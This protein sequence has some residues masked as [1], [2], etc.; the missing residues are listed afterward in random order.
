M[1]Q[2]KNA[3]IRYVIAV[4]RFPEVTDFD[5]FVTEMSRGLADAYPSGKPADIP[6]VNVHVDDNGVQIQSEVLRVWQFRS[7]DFGWA[8]AVN[9]N[10]VALH[11]TSYVGHEDFLE[12][13]LDATSVA[14]KTESGQ[15]RMVEGAA[16][17]YLDLV[18]PDE[19]DRLEDYLHERFMPAG[20]EVGG[21]ELREGITQL[22]MAAGEGRTL[23]VTIAR[24]PP[25][26]FPPDLN[27][28]LIQDNR[29]QIERPAADFL[30]IDTD[31]ALPFVPPRRLDLDRLRADVFGLWKP[32][33]DAFDTIVTEHA[34][35]VWK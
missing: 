17:R 4:V 21:F 7:E 29:W 2:M 35:E 16:L 22:Q 25:S 20:V 27:S 28:Q 18:V 13:L 23:R 26:V 11:T 15:V 14:L 10:M 3:P 33:R 32:I 8:V 9:K 6:Q 30:I 12:R 24:N 5:T 1:A 31:H 19:S 34:M